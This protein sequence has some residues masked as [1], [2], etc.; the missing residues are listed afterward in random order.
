MDVLIIGGGGREH[1]IALQLKKSKNLGKLY[2]APGN[3]GIAE[4]AECVDI[5]VM[6]FDAII[7]FLDSHPNIG[8]TV[9]APDNPLAEGLVDKLEQHG[10]RAFGPRKA[11]ARIESSKVFAKHLMKKYNIPSAEYEVFDDYQKAAEYIKGAK[12]PLVVKADG[13][14][15]GKGVIICKNLSE[16]AEALQEIMQDKKFGASGS[17]VVIEEFLEGKEVSVLT[18]CDGVTIVPMP[19]S[20][21]HK[22]AFDNDLGPNTGGMGAFCPSL[23]YNEK[24]ADYT[25]TNIILPTVSALA[26]E[27]CPFK[28]VLYFGLMVTDSGVKVL[29]YNAR[30]GDPETQAILPLLQT[31]LLEIMNAVVDQRLSEIDIKWSNEVCL[32]VIVASGGYPGDFRRGMEIS[33]APFEEGITLFHAG[34]KSDK[35]RLVTSGGR[36]IGVGAKGSTLAE[37]RRRV[38]NNIDKIRFDNSFYRKDIGVDHD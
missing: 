32:C 8:L 29:E 27:G 35:G 26:A 9:V 10:H 7:E 28:G 30:F 17:S 19:A 14:A 4:L 33:I 6:D 1:A 20:Q 36:V 18:F 38:Y 2:C 22:R 3:G 15:Y 34:T 25:Y 12:Y 31:D 24:V 16:A 21:D 37:C 11:A 23:I 5:S 13:L